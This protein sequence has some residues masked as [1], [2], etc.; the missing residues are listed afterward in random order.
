M[1]EQVLG[2]LEA[3]RYSPRR[4]GS[5]RA[6]ASGRPCERSRVAAISGCSPRRNQA[7]GDLPFEQ[8]EH[9]GGGEQHAAQGGGGGAEVHRFFPAGRR[10]RS[11]ESRAEADRPM[12]VAISRLIT[13]LND[14]GWSSTARR[15][16]RR[17]RTSRP[18]AP[19]RTSAGSSSCSDWEKGITRRRTSAL[20]EGAGGGRRAGPPAAPRATSR[21][22]ARRKAGSSS[23]RWPGGVEA[24]HDLDLVPQLVAD[25]DAGR[26]PAPCRAVPFGPHLEGE[27]GGEARSELLPDLG[28]GQDREAAASA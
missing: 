13:W 11:T 26:R 20:R 16:R 22:A 21:R 23:R 14:S 24:G 7:P 10:K 28:P 15:Q 6:R 9:R 1:L 8:P 3:R 27:A 4:A 12:E 19:G 5:S 18:R 2:R 25:V 17:C